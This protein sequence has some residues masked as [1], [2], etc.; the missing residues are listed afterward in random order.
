MQ[1]LRGS[2]YAELSRQIKAS[3]LL[4]ARPG[5]YALQIS[6]VLALCA[7]GAVVF[8]LAGDSWWQLLVAVAFAVLS[9]QVGFLSH[10]AGHRQI[11]RTARANRLA[12][13]VFTNLGVGFSYGWW[14]D[15]HSRHHA[16]PNDEDKD[17]DVEAGALVFTSG[18]ARAARGPARMFYRYQAWAFFPLLTLEALNLRVS[19]VRYLLGD[20]TRPRVR[21]G[22]LILAHVVAYLTAVFLVLSPGK[23]VLFVVVHQGLFGVYLGCSFAPNHK[24]MPPLSAADDANYLR[25]QVLTSRNIRGH[26]LTD[27]TLGGLNY[28]IEHHL[29][30]SMPRVNLRHAQPLVRA[31]C[32]GRG[33]SYLETG[34]I[35]SY[36]MVLRHLD[37]V[38]NLQPAGSTTR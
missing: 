10:D 38:G 25:R 7:G 1:T 16:H 17:P 36:A 11:F 31:F 32:A 24:G 29:F 12:G 4:D 34:L 28:Q 8:L 18:Q 20:R 13:L 3:G 22:L 26:W 23:A 21:E 15:K 19:S 9:T 37:T 33:V 27:L 2:E 6:V 14:V 5:Y 35:P 30:P